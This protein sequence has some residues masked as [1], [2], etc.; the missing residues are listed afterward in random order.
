MRSKERPSLLTRLLLIVSW[1]I[2][3]SLLLFAGYLGWK[4][5]AESRQAQASQSQVAVAQAPDKPQDDP[6]T[7]AS[8]PA[9]QLPTQ[10]RDIYRKAL[11]HTTIPERPS[12]KVQEYTVST[13]DSVFEIAAK[14]KIKPETLLW[15]NYDQLNDNPDTISLGMELAIPPTDGV[16]YQWQKG[17]TVESVAGRFEAR[18]DDILSWSENNADLT[19]PTFEPGTWI[20]VPKGHREFR[21]WV[22]PVIPRGRAGV[23]KSVYGEGACEG[24]Y[25]GAYG[26]GG[27]VWPAGNHS[28]SGNDFW[29]GHLGID[30]AAGEGAPIYAADSGVVVF[31]GWATGGYGYT[32][33]LDHGNGYQ[34]LYG[35]LSQIAAS[36]GRSVGQGQTIAYAGSTGNSTGAHLHFEVRYEGGFVS[37][38]FVLPAP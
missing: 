34:T 11:S 3:L 33:V 32:V 26:T 12:E 29:S 23:S 19:N 6:S 13:G 7:P 16:Y 5:L 25:D 31:S 27:F 36:C 4:V 38:W 10:V 20:M 35:H 8:L 9:V 22:I 17:D 24:G 37:P 30:I 14:F 2:A 21:Q 18:V 15:A 1:A 28:L